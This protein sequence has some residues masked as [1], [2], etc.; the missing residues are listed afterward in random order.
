MIY[1]FTGQPGSGKT[2]LGELLSKY[3][4][5]DKICTQGTLHIDG[6]DIRGIFNDRDYSEAGRRKNIQRAHDIA[7]FAHAKG[8]NVIITLVSPYRDLRDEFK[9]K[10]PVVEIYV[11][12]TEDRGRTHFFVKD[13]EPPIDDKFIDI[14]TTNATI[15][16]TFSKLIDYISRQKSKH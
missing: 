15:I 12:T 8:F 13:Y 6:D 9:A 7:Q 5:T 1:Y 4:S 3:L 16:N 14:D 2:R 10:L 11:H